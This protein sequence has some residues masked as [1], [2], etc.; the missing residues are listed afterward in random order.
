MLL[1]TI[2][3]YILLYATLYIN[4]YLLSECLR[5]DLT[6]GRKGWMYEIDD[7][8]VCEWECAFLGNIHD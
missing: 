8:I 4:I 7:Y 2:N 5:T 6:D 1:H 3:I